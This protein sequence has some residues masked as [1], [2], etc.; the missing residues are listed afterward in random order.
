MQNKNGKRVV[1]LWM[2]V[3]CF[4]ERVISYFQKT[5]QAFWK[6]CSATNTNEKNYLLSKYLLSKITAT[7]Y[8]D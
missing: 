6:T 5:E 4:I 3:H 1:A 2:I 8:P 7:N